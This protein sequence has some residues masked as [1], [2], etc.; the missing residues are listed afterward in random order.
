LKDLEEDLIKNFLLKFP[1]VKSNKTTLYVILIDGYTGMGKSTV[2]KCISKFDGSVIL[3]N[4]EV[5]Y[6]L[7]DYKNNNYKLLQEYRLKKLLENNNSCVIDSCF[8]HNYKSKLELYKK[9]GIKYYIIRLECSDEVVKKRLEERTINNGNYSIANYDDYL[10]MKDNVERVPMNLIDFVI[11]TEENIDEQV[12]DFL[13][14]Y[15]LIKSITLK[16]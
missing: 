7:N 9:L 15:N 6:F 12:I 11:N 8:C 1:I 16:R 13:T 3:N 2:A 10:W 4:D 14:K 5:R